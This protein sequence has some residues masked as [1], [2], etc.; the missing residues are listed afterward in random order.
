[1]GNKFMLSPVIKQ[2]KEYICFGPVFSHIDWCYPSTECIVGEVI[3]S[4]GM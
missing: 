3:S 1:M 4:G 2:E